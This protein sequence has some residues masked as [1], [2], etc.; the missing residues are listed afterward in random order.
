MRY[1]IQG[2]LHEA[3]HLGAEAGAALV[4]GIKSAAKLFPIAVAQEGKYKI[5]TSEH[6]GDTVLVSVANI[7]GV[8]GEK[9]TLRLSSERAGHRGFTL[10]ALGLHGAALERV[11][12]MLHAR[13]GLVLVAGKSGSGKTTALYTLL[14]QLEGSRASIV[15]VEEE[16]EHQLPYATQTHTRPDAGFTMI[17]GCARSTPHRPGRAHD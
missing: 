6:D 3:M 12:T 16:I 9:L 17:A 10:S 13:S 4:Q 1:R 2:V 14:D 8:D 7:A 5:E 11:H 15:T